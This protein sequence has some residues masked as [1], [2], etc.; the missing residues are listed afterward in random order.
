MGQVALDADKKKLISWVFDAHCNPRDTLVVRGNK[1]VKVQLGNQ[2]AWVFKPGSY[3]LESLRKLE[4]KSWL[5]KTYLCKKCGWLGTGSSTRLINHF[6]SALK[7]DDV[8]SGIGA[9][10]AKACCGA[11]SAEETN[12]IWLCSQA[13]VAANDSILGSR[14][15][16]SRSTSNVSREAVI[17]PSL[18]PVVSAKASDEADMSIL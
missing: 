6:C 2:E 15:L 18:A 7:S 16:H 4:I 8:Q 12:M 13:R 9:S 3:P 11:F 1:Q 14:K 5:N 17:A 10:R